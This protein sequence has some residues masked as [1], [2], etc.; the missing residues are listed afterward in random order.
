MPEPKYSEKIATFSPDRRYRYSLYRAWDDAE[1]W[2]KKVLFVMLNPS[3]ADENVLDPTVRRCVGYAQDWGFKRI[4]IANI[5]ALRSTDPKMLYSVEDP[6]GPDNDQ[7]IMR[8]VASSDLV[9]AAWGTHGAYRSRGQQVA[10]DIAFFKDVQCLG[11]SNGGFPLHPLYLRKDLKPI[12]FQ[13]EGVV[14]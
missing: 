8:M 12:L 1:D 13:K 9:I 5:F 4:E 3:T 7:A 11:R 2:E 10:N 14:L 6:V